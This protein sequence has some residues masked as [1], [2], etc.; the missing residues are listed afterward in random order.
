MLGEAPVDL[1][2]RPAWR[3]GDDAIERDAI[4]FW[5]RMAILP[6]DVTPED[7]ARELAA[8]AYRDGRLVGVATAV[9][10]PVEQLRGNFAFFRCAVDPDE[11]RS[12]AST[13]LTVFARDLIEQWSADR[14]EENVLGLASVI[15]SSALRQRQRDPVWENTRLNLVGFTPDG[16]QL[17]VAWFAHA[18]VPVG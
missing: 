7:R 5:N 12:L 1:D 4:D 9:V 17:R 6:A 8:A 2:L 14:P 18:R 11:R 15:V 10:G 13:A 3:L 16:R